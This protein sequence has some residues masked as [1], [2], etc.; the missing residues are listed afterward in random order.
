MGIL[1]LNLSLIQQI[2]P[3]N[4]QDGYWYKI[5]I[6]NRGIYKIDGDFLKK[7][8]INLSQFNPK[9]F[10]IYAYDDPLN[11]K[12]NIATFQSKPKKV[13][14]YFEGEISTI[15]TDQTSFI[16]F[17]ENS[18]GRFFNKESGNWDFHRHSF[19]EFNYY[20]IHLKDDS[21]QYIQEQ[22]PA[23][24][25]TNVI[26]FYG[27]DDLYF[28]N[29]N[30]VRSG[31]KW[32][33]T[34]ITNSDNKKLS[35]SLPG[36]NTN[37]PIQINGELANGSI[38]PA[39]INLVN[40]N[41]IIKTNLDKINSGRYEIKAI[42][43]SFSGEFIPV[44]NNE[45]L[46]ISIQYEA[47][48]GTG[49]LNEIHL[50]YDKKTAF[51]DNFEIFYSKN[52]SLNSIDKNTFKNQTDQIIFIQD[53]NSNIQILNNSIWEI[54]IKSRI[55]AANKTKLPKPENLIPA[56]FIQYNKHQ[57]S[58]LIIIGS[59][60][61]KESITLYKNYKTEQ[62]PS[63]LEYLENIYN[64]YSGGKID[65]IAIRNFLYDLKNSQNFPLKYVL[66]LGDATWDFKNLLEFE[67][68][69]RLNNYIPTFES[70]ESFAPLSSFASDDFFGITNTDASG[71]EENN[72]IPY[73]LELAI[74]RVT[75][76]TNSELITYLNKVKKY[77]ENLQKLKI[78]NISLVADNGDYGIHLIDAESFGEKI[79]K[80]SPI[81]LSKIYLD[82]FP[83]QQKNGI[84]VSPQAE[85][86]LR[87]KFYSNTNLIHYIGHGSVNGWTDE[88]IF[89]TNSIL[90]LKNLNQLPILFTATCDFTKFD[91]PYEISGGELGLLSSTGGWPAII[92][93]TRP[94]FQY[95]NYLFGLNFYDALIENQSTDNYLLGDLFK[96]TKNKAGNKLS[97]RNISLLGDPTLQLPWNYKEI[98]YS[99]V[100]N[101]GGLNIKLNQAI[102]EEYLEIASEEE[103]NK[104][105]NNQ[106]FFLEDTKVEQQIKANELGNSLDYSINI[107]NNDNQNN[108]HIFWAG[109]NF[110]GKK[111]YLENLISTIN[112]KQE[113]SNI[114]PNYIFEHLKYFPKSN[115]TLKI[116]LENISPILH[117]DSWASVQINDSL[118]YKLGEYF[119]QN[120]SNKNQK[121]YKFPL[122]YNLK[123]IEG[124]L[125]F[126]DNTL[127]S[128]TKNFN[129][130]ISGEISEKQIILYPNPVGI[131]QNFS[132]QKLNDQNFSEKRINLD[133]FNI[134]GKIIYSMRNKLLENNYIEFSLDTTIQPGV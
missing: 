36:L 74:G 79:L 100:E 25:Q 130:N 131:G 19:Q 47:E 93:T 89:T 85:E 96:D 35:Y 86:E 8:G 121:I 111:I 98:E 118:N 18:Y 66:L 28:E 107:P 15:W 76:A 90:T 6:P 78:P 133:I 45:K 51:S 117:F 82:N 56:N 10:A 53:T 116:I 7:N 67:S 23:N 63:S 13:P 11:E 99:I 5:K 88:K 30:I 26:E 120:E 126:W 22:S 16:F 105:L 83:L 112:L 77:D 132:I 40:G 39:T 125:I 123:T 3:Q 41:S 119:I 38:Y 103:T 94:V 12:I 134:N 49:Y 65:P 70:K 95:S 75:V 9:E 81:K 46:E 72:S 62:L 21:P 69:E 24:T 71:F 91:D 29:I 115:D 101:S 61:L 64:N 52:S 68:E 124:K 73:N 113:N 37:S 80:N 97:N 102:Q 128:I 54:P 122:P 87:N 31:R 58:S 34:S 59:E 109:R 57:N 14:I 60:N 104:T 127:E 27:L 50:K 2:F 92:S 43:K 55:L 129:F 106:Q 1:F 114:T 110:E 84:D 17:A 33:G 108:K 20:F 44:L 42:T 4:F 48:G 32:L